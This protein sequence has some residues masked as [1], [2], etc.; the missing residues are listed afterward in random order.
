MTKFLYHVEDHFD[1]LAETQRSAWVSSAYKMLRA[2]FG[3]A[4][5]LMRCRLDLAR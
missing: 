1:A 3:F 2:V 4:G 5:D